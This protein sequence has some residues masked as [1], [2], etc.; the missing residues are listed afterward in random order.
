MQRKKL[1][2]GHSLLELI[3]VVAM[4]GILAAIIVTHVTSENDSSKINACQTY[5]G[6]IEIQAE[7][8]IH[9]QGSLPLAN[10]SDIGA[11]TAYFPEGLPT[12]PVD[13]TAYTIDTATG[14]VVGHNH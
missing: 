4:I 1:H 3:A 10:L 7:L 11:V 13:G 5:K 12:C 2:K 6:N 14:L 8:W 9:N